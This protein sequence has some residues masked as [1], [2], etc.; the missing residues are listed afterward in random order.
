VTPDE[1]PLL[2]MAAP[3]DV[4]VE[5]AE[6]LACVGRRLR[7]AA[8]EELSPLGLTW[9]QARLLR[10]LADADCPLRMA[11]I[12]ARLGVVARSATSM[13]DAIEVAGLVARQSDPRDRRSV[14]VAVTPTGSHLLAQLDAARRMAAQELCSHIDENERSELTRLLR[15]LLQ[16]EEV[17]SS[18]RTP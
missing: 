13:V 5:L 17:S 8:Q 3:R 10:L 2:S 16:D 11:D 12:A 14:L 6:L 7:R 18:S 9:A 1:S 4:D 15:R